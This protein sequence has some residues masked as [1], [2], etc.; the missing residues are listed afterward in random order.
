MRSTSCGFDDGPSFSGS[1]LLVHAGPTLLVDIGFDMA[2]KSDG[3]NGHPNLGIKGVHALVDTGATTSCI[4]SQLAIALNLPIV[5]Q[6]RIA[7]VSGERTVN[8]HLA[9]ILIPSLDFTVYGQFAGVDLAAGGQAHSALIGRTFLKNFKMVYDGT[10]GQVV[11]C[12]PD[13]FEMPQLNLG[14]S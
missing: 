7:G 11:I 2:F 10:T 4:D 8:M 9:Q 14:E 13:A 6:S 5:D 3:S 12:E 1:D